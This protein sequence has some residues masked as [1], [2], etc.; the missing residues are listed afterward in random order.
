MAPSLE[1]LAIQA[2]Q[3]VQQ[4]EALRENVRGLRGVHISSCT[5]GLAHSAW[6]LLAVVADGLQL[7]A[8]QRPSP[9]PPADQ[10]ACGHSACRQNWIETGSARC[11]D[12][13]VSLTTSDRK[14]A[15]EASARG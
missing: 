13:Q 10:P 9:P 11:V 14:Q 8:K 1:V 6:L 7:E 5:E 12:G 3:I 15:Q 4:V 2:Q